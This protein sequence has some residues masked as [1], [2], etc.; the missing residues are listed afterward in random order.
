MVAQPSY[1]MFRCFSII[2]ALCFGLSHNFN[3]FLNNTHNQNLEKTFIH[4]DFGAS[5][6]IWDRKENRVTG[7]ID[8][9]GSG[10]GDPAY[11]FAGILSS[12]GEEFFEICTNL[13]PGGSQILERVHF[14]RSTFALQEDNGER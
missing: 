13:Y 11:D 2:Q 3:T 5:N 1:G 14:Y 12:Y 9:G 6:I 8:F 7:V 10:L 4:G